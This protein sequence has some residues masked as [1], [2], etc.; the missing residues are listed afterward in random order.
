[1]AKELSRI[2]IE[3][4]ENGGHTVTHHHKEAARKDSKSHSGVSMVYHE[5]EHHVFGKDEGHEMLAHIANH[6]EIP[7]PKGEK[8]REAEDTDDDGEE[9]GEE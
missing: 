8:E 4:A 6:L 3:P 1:M 7:E 2:E 9:E 5:P